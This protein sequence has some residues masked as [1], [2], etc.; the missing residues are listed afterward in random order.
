LFSFARYFAELE[1]EIWSQER[2]EAVEMMFLLIFRRF[3]SSELAL[4]GSNWLKQ[5]ETGSN[6][7]KL[8]LTGSNWLATGPIWPQ[9]VVPC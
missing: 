3:S 1:P 8:A 9:A 6:R 7:T 5:D 2:D 4:T